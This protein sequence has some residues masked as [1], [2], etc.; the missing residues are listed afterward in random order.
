MSAEIIQLP[1]H[2]I[3]SHLVR[4]KTLFSLARREPSSFCLFY[5]CDPCIVLGSNNREEEWV[6][7]EAARAD[8]VPVIRRFS[9]GGAV[10][11]DRNVLNYSFILP[12]ERLDALSLTGGAAAQSTTTRYID[13]CRSLVIRALAQLSEGF[14]A[15][16]ISDISL[17]GLKIS[18]NA[19]R[20]AA[21]VV[22]HHGTL[23]L[24][25]PLDAIER[26]LPIPP[27]RPG[28]SHRYFLTGLREQGLDCNHRELIELISQGFP[29]LSLS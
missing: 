12:R 25:C 4:E 5:T 7:A 11:L 17:N 15:T 23:M 9:G 1:D 29:A 2:D 24:R 18:G 8:G 10:Y 20:I 3:S 16:G 21:N 14:C 13:A 19:Q 22:L 6:H 28:V 26:Y 27:N